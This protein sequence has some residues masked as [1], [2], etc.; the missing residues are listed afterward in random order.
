MT[1]LWMA[2]SL[3]QLE[4]EDW[5]Q[6]TYDSYVVKACH[7][8]RKKP[9]RDLSNEELR[10]AI[11]QE[12]SLKFLLPV[13]V[14]RLSADPLACGDFYAGDLLLKVMQVAKGTWQS[15]PLKALRK[16]V[17]AVVSELLASSSERI[18]ANTRERI[19]SAYSSLARPGQN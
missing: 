10:L 3:E 7:A 11:G 17:I 2:K 6:P 15:P 18:D 19:E 13:A 16:R 1:G 4:G 14:D 8:L 5:G 9:V 12:M